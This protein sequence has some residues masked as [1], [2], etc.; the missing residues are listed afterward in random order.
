[1]TPPRR[2]RVLTVLLDVPV[3]P[4]TGLHLR[5]VANL[6]L[7][8]ALGCESHA[9][10][11]STADRSDIQSLASLCDGV[12][13]AGP[14]HEYE[15]IPVTQRIA[16]R[17][18]MALGA[19][20]GRPSAVYPFS[21]PYDLAGARAKLVEAVGE[22][23]ID[24]VVL[25]TSLLHLA[26]AIAQQG[27]SV[28]G[29]AVDVLSQLTRKLLSYGRGSPARIPGLLVNHAASRTQERLFLPACDEIWATT[30]TEALEFR[31]LLPS[32]RVFVTG[33]TIDEHEVEPLNTRVV[34]P[35]GF[36]GTYSSR[37]NLDAATYL[38]DR[39]FPPL[40]AARPQTRLALAGAGLPTDLAKRF[41][42][43]PGVEVLGPVPD[44]AAFLR[45]CSVLAF[46]IHVRGGLPLKLV[47]GF[48][49]GRPVVGTSRLIDGLPVRPGEDL[50]VAD[51]PE[52][53]ADHVRRILEDHH[54]AVRLGH[55]GRR[56]FETEFSFGASLKRA[57]SESLLGRDPSPEPGEQPRPYSGGGS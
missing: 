6:R 39:V 38:V 42:S 19:L 14:R 32:A 44:S 48:A 36:I 4:V 1:M 24:V 43:I 5:Q 35:V 7:I 33:N 15:N 45:S 51:E 17:A 12:V 20:C 28:I 41:R 9:F 23:R 21:I 46:P 27:V 52:A 34:G 13:D 22:T 37:P 50:L 56:V 26:P 54:L 11:F 47:E 31:R 29:D 3:P 49:C 2:H 25:P 30:S 10:V 57:R 8:R 55:N 18:G 16:L 53:F 40:R